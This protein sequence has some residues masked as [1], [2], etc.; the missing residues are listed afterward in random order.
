VLRW[1]LYF[2][3]DRNDAGARCYYRRR[4][5]SIGEADRQR[6]RGIVQ[7]CVGSV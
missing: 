4:P 6:A 2:G 5:L 3:V 1:G 7:W